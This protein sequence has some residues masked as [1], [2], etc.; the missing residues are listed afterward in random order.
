VTALIIGGVLVGVAAIVVIAS[1]VGG[2]SSGKSATGAASTTG[3]HASRTP[4]A[5]HSASGPAGLNV[6]VLN[7]TTTNGLAHLVSGELRQHGY[8]RASPLKGR[9]PGTNQVTTVEYSSGHRAD[10]QAV[11]RYVHAEQVQPIESAVTSLAGSANVVVIV[12]ADRTSSAGSGGE[13]S[14]GGGAEPSGGSG[15]QPSGGG[16]GESSGGAAAASP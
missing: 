6:V 11:A 5:S 14:G 15:A 3:A 12:G 4:G 13:A 8:S 7:G 9:P 16:G 1:S 2:G 10:A